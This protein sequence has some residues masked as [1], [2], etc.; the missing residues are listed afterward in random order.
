MIKNNQAKRHFSYK[1]DTM[2]LVE[3]GQFLRETIDYR[4]E[5]EWQILLDRNNGS[6]IGCYKQTVKSPLYK[7]RN[8]DLALIDKKTNKLILVIELDGDIHRV[9]E[10]DTEQ[11]NDDYKKAGIP[12][13]IINQWEIDTTIFD[14]VTKE[15]NQRGLI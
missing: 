12:M 10:M 3:L 13:I 9:K 14:C 8:P 15:L 6:F 11:R 4:V 2:N 1:N 5:R 7:M